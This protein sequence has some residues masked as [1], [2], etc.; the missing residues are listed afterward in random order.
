MCIV[1]TQLLIDQ[2]FGL[3]CALSCLL[4]PL[5]TDSGMRQCSVEVFRSI[6]RPVRF[7]RIVLDEVNDIL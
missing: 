1:F 5:R 6:K 2:H 4:V 7:S 3:V